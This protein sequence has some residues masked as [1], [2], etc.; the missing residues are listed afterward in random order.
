MKRIILAFMLVFSF[1]K[2]G[3]VTPFAINYGACLQAFNYDPFTC[4][5]IKQIVNDVREIMKLAEMVDKGVK[6]AEKI[7]VNFLK[8]SLTSVCYYYKNM[9]ALSRKY[10]DTYEILMPDGTLSLYL[11]SEDLLKVCYSDNVLKAFRDL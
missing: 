10:I 8:E 11:D 6:G 2:A 4:G 5:Y 3:D 9:N 1:S 7:Y